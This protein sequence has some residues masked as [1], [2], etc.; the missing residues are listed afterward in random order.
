M[1]APTETLNPKTPYRRKLTVATSALAA[2]AVL[3]GIG[4][5]V[6]YAATPT[7]YALDIP[8]STQRHMQWDIEKA[9]EWAD[10]RRDTCS[11]A[12]F[13]AAEV[14]ERYASVAFRRDLASAI[15][16][17]GAHLPEIS[18]WRAQ[19]QGLH[20]R[21]QRSSAADD[22]VQMMSVS[23]TIGSGDNWYDAMVGGQF[24]RQTELLDA[25]DA[26]ST[27]RA[28][29][30]AKAE[31]LRSEY[32]DLAEWKLS[33]PDVQVV[34]AKDVTVPIGLGSAA[35]VLGLS[36]MAGAAV[37]TTRREDGAE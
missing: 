9:Q 31:F 37:L 34:A 22:A 7:T 10:A 24:A 6:T 26:A 18:L 21:A 4:A 17:S 12:G 11:E 28:Q 29:A 3:F 25:V 16:I 36:A 2:S 27:P 32:P 14:D 13:C 1:S 33:E 23:D 8:E 30:E 19:R 35:G 5:T 15:D 20:D